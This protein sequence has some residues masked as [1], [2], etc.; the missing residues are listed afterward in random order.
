MNPF[1]RLSPA[2]LAPAAL[3]C[4]LWF[5]PACL[6][7]EQ[8][9][10]LS[11][12]DAYRA[13]PHERTKFDAAAAAMPAAERD[14]LD[15]FFGL[16]D[17]A[18]VARVARQQGGGEDGYA[19]ILARLK[20]LDVPEKLKP[21]HALVVAAVTEQRDYLQ[22]SKPGAGLDAADPLVSDSHAKLLAAYD[23]LMRLYPA[24][25]GHNKKA[26]YNHLCALDF[27]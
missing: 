13:I 3:I 18:V 11:V 26:F 17:D 16:T 4:S 27:M 7:G 23:E 20:A 8:K 24:E 10:P 12:E 6:A 15:I 22:K 1:S 21:A 5:A 14:F 2:F 9:P 25:N 19:A